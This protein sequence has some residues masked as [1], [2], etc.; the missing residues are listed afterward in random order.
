MFGCV[1]HCYVMS[2]YQMYGG[3]ML[4]SVLYG[5]VWSD[6]ILCDVLSCD[7][8]FCNVVLCTVVS[9]DVE[10][11][12]LLL[13]AVEAN[14]AARKVDSSIFYKPTHI[15]FIFRDLLLQCFLS[16]TK[17]QMHI[18]NRNLV[19]NQYEPCA[20]Q[21]KAHMLWKWRLGPEINL[22]QVCQSK[23]NCRSCIELPSKPVPPFLH[24]QEAVSQNRRQASKAR[25]PPPVP[26]ARNYSARNYSIFFPINSR[27]PLDFF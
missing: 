13:R 21:C 14:F 20:P 26:L 19:N 27:C 25:G 23:G 1:M 9:C 11:Y 7:V 15:M 6:V 8:M 22:L 24:V 17:L 5:C 4:G 12:D 18:G 2:C 10:S 16:A 3:V